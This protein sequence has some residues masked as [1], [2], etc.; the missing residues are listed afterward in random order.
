MCT[1]CYHHIPYPPRV[2]GIWVPTLHMGIRRSDGMYTPG[3]QHAHPVHACIHPW[4]AYAPA[5]GRM[6]GIYVPPSTCACMHPLRYVYIPA[7]T[8]TYNHRI[9][10]ISAC[11]SYLHRYVDT[12]H[13]SP[14]IPYPV[15]STTYPAYHLYAPVG[16][17][18]GIPGYY[19]PSRGM[20]VSCVGTA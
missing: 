14:D 2:G 13:T 16:A 8:T 18:T 3:V 9:L 5:T 6:C 7:T 4:V 17:P 12:L 11:S 1:T 20:Y 15:E 10:H 19:I